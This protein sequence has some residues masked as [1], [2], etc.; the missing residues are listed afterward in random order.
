M[1]SFSSTSGPGPDQDIRGAAQ[2]TIDASAEVVYDLITD[3]ARM[4]EWSP[5]CYRTEIHGVADRLT[6]GA[7]F[8]GFNRNGTTWWDVPCKVLDATP[9]HRFQFEAPTGSEAATVWTFTLAP[10]GAST[11]VVEDFVAPM[12]AMPETPAGQIPDRRDAMIVGMATTLQ[13]IKRVAEAHDGPR[14]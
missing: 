1:N 10:S 2:V 7:T 9:G 6:A 12:L 8:Q 4:G 3:L 13:R 11:V 14:R 5:E